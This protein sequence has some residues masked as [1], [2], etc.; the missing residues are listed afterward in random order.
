MG[1][2]QVNGFIAAVVVAVLG[3]LVVRLVL[4]AMAAPLTTDRP[5]T[6]TATATRPYSPGL[7]GVIAG[8]TSLSFID[9]EARPPAVPRLPHRRPRR[10]RARYPAVA[11][12]LWTGEWD[13]AHRLAD[14]PDPGRAS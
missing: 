8:E 2:T 13:P 7:E 11:N 12:L 5:T 10:A 14:R 3:S 4:N 9:G 1:F 6:T